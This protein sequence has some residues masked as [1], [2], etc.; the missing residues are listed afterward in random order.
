M[1]KWKQVKVRYDPL[2]L[3]K[4]FYNFHEYDYFEI[5]II[6]KEPIPNKITLKGFNEKPS[7]LSYCHFFLHDY[8]FERIWNQPKKYLNKLSQFKGILTPDFSLFTDY[9]MAVQIWNTYR[10][11]WVGAYCQENNISVITTIGWSTPTSYDFCFEGVEKCSTVAVSSLGVLRNKDSMTLFE[12]GY[13]E[14]INQI[15]PQ[16]IVFYGDYPT[17][18]ELDGNKIQIKNKIIQKLNR[19]Q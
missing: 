15:D 11:R 16:L 19:Q 2:N 3:N 5:P 10:N 12:N 9:P 13:N 1:D 18:K 8:Q 14:M 4:G 17:Y 6:K 7:S